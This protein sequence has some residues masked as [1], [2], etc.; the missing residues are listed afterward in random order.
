MERLEHDFDVIDAHHHYGDIR[1]LGVELSPEL[2]ELSADEYERLERE[3]RLR[4][5][6]AQGVRQAVIMGGHSYLRPDGI[7]DTRH[8]NDHVASYRDA[9]PERFPAALG[10][11]EPLYGTRGLHEI[12]RIANELGMV[13]VSFHVRFQGVSLDSPLVSA[14]VERMAV[15]GLVPFIHAPADSP[16]NALWKVE[17]VAQAFPDLTMIVVDAFSN[18][19][20]TREIPYV[21]DRNP[22][23]VFDTSLSYSFGFIERFVRSH[24]W[25]RVVFG[26]DIYSMTPRGGHLLAEIISSKLDRE[27]RQSILGSN[28]RRIL[29]LD[30]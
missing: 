11:V 22:N 1:A 14:C 7:S 15:N 21:A 13:G 16:E 5:M 20:Q 3:V 19:E 4:A 26:T 23:L 28:L 2:A 24:G 27:V 6:D 8:L 17:T 10:I 9:M 12:D 29:G 25:E 30:V 18:F